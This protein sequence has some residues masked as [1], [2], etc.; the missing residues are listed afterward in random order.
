MLDSRELRIV[1]TR[2]LGEFFRLIIEL[3]CYRT[4][5]QP[6]FI[7]K[8]FRASSYVINDPVFL[9]FHT[10][11]GARLAFVCQN[12]PMGHVSKTGYVLR[13]EKCSHAGAVS[14][15]ICHHN[16]PPVALIETVC[17]SCRRTLGFAPKNLKDLTEPC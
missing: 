13:G 16:K 2:L 5:T 15:I 10:P 9:G 6:R 11:F 1:D 8:H 7:F 12:R 4:E 14:L 3:D 17:R